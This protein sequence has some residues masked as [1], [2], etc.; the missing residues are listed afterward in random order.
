MR[1][2]QVST[3]PKMTPQQAPVLGMQATTVPAAV[4][5]AAQ[6]DIGEIMNMMILMIVVVMMMK[7]MTQAT[8][9]IGAP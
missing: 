5:T 6:F 8:A 2:M 4:T 1:A 7:V 3:M 9:G